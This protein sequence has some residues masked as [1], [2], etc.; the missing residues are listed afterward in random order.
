MSRSTI[1]TQTETEFRKKKRDYN[2]R[3]WRQK[4]TASPEYAECL[5]SRSEII[6]KIHN[7]VLG[8]V[9][10]P[11]HG[12]RHDKIAELDRWINAIYRRGRLDMMSLAGGAEIAK[13][14]D[15]NDDE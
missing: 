6:V 7:V 10:C 13:F 14:A 5:M 11:A 2:V 15:G 4:Q 1:S 8:N 3:H 9:R 12:P